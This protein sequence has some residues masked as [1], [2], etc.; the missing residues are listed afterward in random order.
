MEPELCDGALDRLGCTRWGSD[1]GPRVGRAR[2]WSQQV[3]NTVGPLGDG[4][5]GWLERERDARLVLLS[6]SAIS[7]SLVRALAG[8][9]GV[10]ALLGVA[11][12]GAVHGQ[13]SH[14]IP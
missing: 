3:G 6:P 2:G 12:S 5:L 13:A 8:G 7:R 4:F 10:N 14:G 1:S 11:E 9:R